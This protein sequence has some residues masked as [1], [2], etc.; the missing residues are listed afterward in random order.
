[1]CGPIPGN[2]WSTPGKVWSNLFGLGQKLVDPGHNL[3]EVVRNRPI[4]GHN[5]PEFGRF[6]A[7]LADVRRVCPKVRHIWHKVPRNWPGSARSVLPRH[8]GT[9]LRQIRVRRARLTPMSALT[10]RIFGSDSGAN[11]GTN[12]TP[13]IWPTFGPMRADVAPRMG[14]ELVFQA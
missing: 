10:A 12:P 6:L 14:S 9:D 5:R 4:L 11:V 7:K 8:A 1:M 13:N 2:L 3:F